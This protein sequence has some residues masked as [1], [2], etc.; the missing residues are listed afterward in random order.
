MSLIIADIIY[1]FIHSIE[2]HFNEQL[3]NATRGVYIG[4]VHTNY[5]KQTIK[6]YKLFTQK[7]LDLQHAVS[8]I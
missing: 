8:V 5:S 3:R 7:N 1:E 6:L 2:H 4:D